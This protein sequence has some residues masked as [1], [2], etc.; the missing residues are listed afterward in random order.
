MFL[1]RVPD[2]PT[3]GAR[4]L[5]RI[6]D[7]EEG[8]RVG[9]MSR[10]FRILHVA[11]AVPPDLAFHEG[12][13]WL[14]LE[15]MKGPPRSSLDPEAPCLE[16]AAEHSAGVLPGLVLRA[17]RPDF[18]TT[19]IPTAGPAGA[20]ASPVPFAAPREVPLRI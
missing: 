2:L 1:W 15:P 9:A 18:G 11:D 5:L 14:G 13:M 20:P 3:A 7:E 12:L 10:R 16:Y 8:E 19:L 4:L 17:E 6:G